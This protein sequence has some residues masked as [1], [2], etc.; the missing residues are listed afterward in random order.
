MPVVRQALVPITPCTA[1]LGCAFLTQ[2]CRLSCTGISERLKGKIKL[3]LM[4]LAPYPEYHG[5]KE[6]WLPEISGKDTA[7]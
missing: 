7:S 6:I 2:K 5:I 4:S 1:C 3:T